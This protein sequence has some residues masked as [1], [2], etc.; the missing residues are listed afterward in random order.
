MIIM[1]PF[2]YYLFMIV[3]YMLKQW[4][5]YLGAFFLFIFSLHSWI[6]EA[7]FMLSSTDQ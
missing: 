5:D 3:D 2:L 7:K 4:T 6:E 1:L